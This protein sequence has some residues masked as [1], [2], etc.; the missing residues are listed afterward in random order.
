MPADPNDGRRTR[1]AL[2]TQHTRMNK[3]NDGARASNNVDLSLQDRKRTPAS[4]QAV[5]GRS[6][7]QLESK[8]GMPIRRRRCRCS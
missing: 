8:R 7:R 6:R 2:H 5:D 1:L 3:I 4:Q